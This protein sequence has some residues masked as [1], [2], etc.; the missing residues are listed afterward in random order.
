[1]Q[2]RPPPCTSPSSLPDAPPSYA[3]ARP[4]RLQLPLVVASRASRRQR[5]ATECRV[6]GRILARHLLTTRACD[7]GCV[8]PNAAA[9]DRGGPED[10]KS[11]RLNSSHVKSTYAVFS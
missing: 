8:S 1:S 5:V 4:E 9:F 11:T 10:R 6:R 3:T 2:F 7:H